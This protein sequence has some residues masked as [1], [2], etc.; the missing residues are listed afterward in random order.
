VNSEHER[1]SILL[2]LV[3]LR[4]LEVKAA[5]M[6]RQ[7]PAP[8][9]Y[10]LLKAAILE[11]IRGKEQNARLRVLLQNE[12]LLGNE[13]PSMCCW[14]ASAPSRNPSAPSPPPTSSW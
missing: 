4:L 12:R 1:Y 8:N 6:V 13:K 7:R 3:D 10:T 14:R 9:P 11:P 2:S 5:A